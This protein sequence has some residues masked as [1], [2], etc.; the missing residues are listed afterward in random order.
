[1]YS[2]Q[3]PQW[4]PPR[5]R[6][7]KPV[8]KWVWY[9]VAGWG[10]FMAVMVVVVAVFDPPKDTSAAPSS[11]PTHGVA[12][13]ASPSPSAP[14]SARVTKAQFGDRWPF[15]HITSGTVR[16]IP[17]DGTFGEVIFVADD[18]RTFALNGIALDAHVPDIPKSEWRKDPEIPGA[19]IDIAP[20]R[21]PV[22][23]ACGL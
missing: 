22:A 14:T 16:C 17:R 1:M 19:S 6:P 7:K 9:V 3:P 4:Q 20:L 23:K 2:Q 12:P 8:P 21:D 13:P 15:V 18:G 5:P 11:T 10:A